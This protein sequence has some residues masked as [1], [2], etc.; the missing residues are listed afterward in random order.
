MN[1]TT[2]QLTTF[3]VLAF[4]LLIPVFVLAQPAYEPLVTIPST[5]NDL[6][7]FD[8]FINGLYILSITIAALLAV[9]KI[10]IAG[11]KWMTTDVA[12]SKG[13]AKKDIEGALLGLIIV[14]SAVLI[15]T[16]I[17][18]EIVEEVDVGITNIDTPTHTSAG[19]GPARFD[20]A[21]PG[22]QDK[23]FG[24]EGAGIATGANPTDE[25]LRDLCENVV[26][27]ACPD[28][29]SYWFE[30][31]AGYPE[32]ACYKGIYDSPSQKCLVKS[33]EIKEPFFDCQK[34]SGLDDN[35]NVAFNCD[36]ARIGCV[37]S[38]GTATVQQNRVK[39]TY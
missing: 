37:N 13:A 24:F 14:L 29:W 36:K 31:A 35:G 27:S 10:I 1:R 8:G 26:Q 23:I 16:V 21:V 18:P 2:K 39:C 38:G 19:P 33:T 3:G 25:K 15:L 20:G 22:P 12:P 11:V 6:T 17:N 4:F 28:G 30:S 7:D 34:T 9:I 5:G 32:A